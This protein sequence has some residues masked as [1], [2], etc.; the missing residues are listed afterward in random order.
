MPKKNITDIRPAALMY[1][2]GLIIA[3]GFSNACLAWADNHSP[4]EQN[5]LVI[6]ADFAGLV[7]TGV[8]YN[9]SR[10]LD[11]FNVRPL[12]P[13][14]DIAAAS[15]SL[16]YN[17]Q[18]W[19]SGTVFVSVVDPGVG[20]ARKSVVLKT[21]NGLYFVSPDNGSLSGPADA[22]G[23]DAVRE[24]DEKVNRIPGSE[25]S[26]TFHG[27]DVYSYTGARLAAGV[28][29]FEQVGPLLEAQVIKLAMAQGE[30]VDGAIHGYVAG[31]AG[32]L[33]N[34]YFN[35]DRDLFASIKPD[36]GDLFSISISHKGNVVWRG[37][38]P[39]ARSFGA[40]PVG[41]N[42]LFMNSSG[43]LSLA[44]NQGS[45]AQTYSIQSGT[46]WEVTVAKK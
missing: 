22:Y 21:S 36:Y 25:W 14:Y 2:R 18:T 4:A 6:Q 10:E 17:A 8:A 9:V 37:E 34:I 39:Y 27:R 19:P 7:M 29:T 46:D 12:I 32:R 24:I 13:L 42:L 20:T 43:A 38:I 30:L 1:L 28:I 5:A 16:E 11:V 3:I 45:F 33:G 23:I 15:A 26:H 41:E 31:G 44:I 35:V 40:V